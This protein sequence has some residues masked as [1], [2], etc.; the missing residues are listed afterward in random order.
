M[1][2]FITGVLAAIAIAVLAAAVL[3]MLQKPAEIAFTT[4]G[5]RI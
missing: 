2:S 3:D 5:A 4:S 1:R